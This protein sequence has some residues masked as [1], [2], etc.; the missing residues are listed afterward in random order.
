MISTTLICAFLVL[1]AEGPATAKTPKPIV[2]KAA[3]LFDG[4]SD[5]LVAERH[6][7]RPGQ[8]DQSGGGRPGRP[9]GRDLD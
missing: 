3:R 9:R 8:D 1:Q 6:G 5:S 2:L 7:R 4:T